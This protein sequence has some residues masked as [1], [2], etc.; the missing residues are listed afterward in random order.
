MKSTTP[1]SQIK[2]EFSLKQATSF[3]GAKIFLEYLEKIR[4]AKALVT[5]KIKLTRNTK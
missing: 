5:A 2:T 4:L 1:V 3:G